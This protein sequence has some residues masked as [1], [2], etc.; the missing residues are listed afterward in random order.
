MVSSGSVRVYR[1]RQQSFSKEKRRPQS[2]CGPKLSN[3]Q[4]RFIAVLSAAAMVMGLLLTQ[5]IHGQIVDM[6]VKAEQLRAKNTSV[7]NENVRLLA[8]RAQLTSKTQVA[9]LAGTKLNLFEPDKGQ[10]RR[11]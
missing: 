8:A 5:C 6:Q 1:P 2:Q 7:A 3:A 11:M 4:V 9:A 10:V